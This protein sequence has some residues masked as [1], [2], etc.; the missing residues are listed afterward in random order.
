MFF[1]G[2]NGDDNDVDKNIDPVITRSKKRKNPSDVITL[3][4]WELIIKYDSYGF[5]LGEYNKHKNYKM[6]DF[7]N[8]YRTLLFIINKTEKDPSLSGLD[9]IIDITSTGT[10]KKTKEFS[11]KIL[12]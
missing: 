8:L 5:I 1:Q 4:Q 12:N 3:D 6:Q 11:E 10:D 7:I 2:N 9:K